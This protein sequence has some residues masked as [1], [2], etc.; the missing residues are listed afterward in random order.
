MPGIG[1]SKWTLLRGICFSGSD[2]R[3][4]KISVWGVKKKMMPQYQ[5]AGING[6]QTPKIH[7]MERR[8]SDLY[9]YV[10][11]GMDPV[12]KMLKR[13]QNVPYL[14]HV[15]KYNIENELLVCDFWTESFGQGLDKAF[16]VPHQ[17]DTVCYYCEWGFFLTYHLNEANFLK[18]KGYEKQ[19]EI[20]HIYQFKWSHHVSL[21]LNPLDILLGCF[22][23]FVLQL[24][25]YCCIS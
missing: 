13:V 14:K 4:T 22:F 10:I 23:C 17:T 8:E 11:W 1:S 24:F 2:K 16:Y 18:Y 19:K 6:F 7:I 25:Y 12:W 5:P 15:E 3:P 21:E 20:F 9:N